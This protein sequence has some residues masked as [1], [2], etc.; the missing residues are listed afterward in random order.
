MAKAVHCSYELPVGDLIPA[1]TTT[2]TV[3]PRRVQMFRCHEGETIAWRFG[4]QSGLVVADVDGVVS[5]PDLYLTTTPT[6]LELR[7]TP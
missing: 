7:R 6:T 5:I 3:T 4:R 2:T 1:Q